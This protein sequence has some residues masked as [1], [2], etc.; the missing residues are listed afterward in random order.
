MT[1]ARPAVARAAEL[2]RDRRR[3]AGRELEDVVD[4]LDRYP[5][6]VLW[7]RRNGLVAILDSIDAALAACGAGDD[8]G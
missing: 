6:P 4:A 3:Q 2:L 7:A 5:S 8:S 1:G